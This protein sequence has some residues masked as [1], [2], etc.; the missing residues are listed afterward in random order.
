MKSKYDI[1]IIGSGL[2]GLLTGNILSKKGYKVVILEKNDH[3]GGCL[4]S[5]DIDGVVFDTG[6]HY[7]G[8]MENDQV[9]YKIFNYLNIFSDLNIRK[10]DIEGFDRM[11]IGDKEYV[12]PSGYS[13]FQQKLESYFPAEKDGI[14]KYIGMMQDIANS[15]ALYKLRPSHFDAQ[16]FYAKYTLGNFWEFVESI[17]H[18]KELQNLLAAQNSLYAGKPESTFLFVHAL[19]TNHYLDGAWRFVDGSKQLADALVEN[20]KRMGGEIFYNELAL[21]FHFNGKGIESVRTNRDHVYHGDKFISA[22]HPIPTME[23]ID[24]DKIRKSYR[25][26]IKNLKSTSSMFNLYV[27]LEDKSLPYMNHNYFYYPNGNVWS[28]SY[29]NKDKF[30]QMLNIFPMADSVDEKYTR[31]LSVLAF[32]DY[33]EV[34]QWENSLVEQRGKDYEDFKEKKSQSM[35]DQLD[36]IFP[37]IRNKI[38]SYRAATPLTFKDYTGTHRGAVYG[39]ER[40]FQNPNNSFMFPRTKVPNLYL[41]GQNLSLHGMLGVSIGALITCS[42]FT[43]LNELIKEINND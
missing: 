25:N 13:R 8:G 15:I 27:V 32:M 18:D 3:P 33:S 14:A 29:Y 12:Y 9:L 42:E 34:S 4:Q 5:F 24:P 11:L 40:D 43:N 6:I 10:L 38:K 1:V 20:F 21:K 31:G 16:K 37:D 41:T 22:M 30:P 36:N 7:V 23:M 26:R 35:I 28:L 2:G 17:T 39:I 19:I